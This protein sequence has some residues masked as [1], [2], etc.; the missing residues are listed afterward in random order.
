M[1]TTAPTSAA[2]HPA[3]DSDLSPTNLA[4]QMCRA[5][6]NRDATAS[7]VFALVTQLAIEQEPGPRSAVIDLAAALAASIDRNKGAKPR[8]DQVDT[9]NALLRLLNETARQPATAAA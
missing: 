9:A 5:V 2:A 8:P 6:L 1:P 3:T 4:T 7:H